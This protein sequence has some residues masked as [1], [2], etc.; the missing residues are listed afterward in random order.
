[1]QDWNGCLI[2]RVPQLSCLEV[3]FNNLVLAL[4][5]LVFIILFAMFAL[6]SVR[7]LTAG[8]DANKLKKAQGTFF[9]AILGLVI[10]SSAYLIL[11]LLETVLGVELTLF[12]IPAN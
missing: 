2:D 10:L 8:D 9:S 3:L 1:M 7:W 12:K 5:G 11:F 4:G 6:G